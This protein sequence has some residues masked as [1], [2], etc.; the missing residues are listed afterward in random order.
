MLINQVVKG[1][2]DNPEDWKI[3]E[4][5]VFNQ[6]KGVGIWIANGFLFVNINGVRLS[7]IDKFILYRGIKK[8]AMLKCL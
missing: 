2:L 3:G 8:L 5:Q 6:K 1:M 4:Y 7:L